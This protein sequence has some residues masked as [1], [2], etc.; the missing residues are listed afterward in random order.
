[1]TQLLRHRLVGIKDAAIVDVRR[2]Y[3]HHEGCH[4]DGL[5]VG[6]H[7]CHF[8]LQPRL[9][10]QGL[11]SLALAIQTDLLAMTV[12]FFFVCQVGQVGARRTGTLGSSTFLRLLF[13]LCVCMCVCVCV[14]K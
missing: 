1:M 9:Q 7:Q 11:L 4:V 6:A 2:D 5:L 13:V 3:H 14:C 12:F 10:Q 8:L